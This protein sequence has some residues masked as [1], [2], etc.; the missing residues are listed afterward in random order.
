MTEITISGAPPSRRARV[1]RLVALIASSLA[2]VTC[3]LVTAPKPG[4]GSAFV[5]TYGGST[6]LVI[7]TP[8]PL[9]VTI[10][11]NGVDLAG[12]RLQVIS[13]NPENIDVTGDDFDHTLNPI[14]RGSTILTVKLLGSTFGDIPPDTTFTV[15]AVAKNLVVTTAA[16]TL[17]SLGDTL[18]FAAKVFGANNAELPGEG[19]AVRWFS[20]D[21]TVFSVDSFSGRVTALKNGA[22]VLQGVL[23][24]DVETTTANITVAQQVAHYT[25]SPAPVL[26]AALGDTARIT[27]TPRDSGGSVVTGVTL[28][29]VT[30]NTRRPG[31]VT[32][33]GAGLITGLL[34][35]TTY[36]VATASVAATTVADSVRVEVGQVAQQVIISQT[37]P[38]NKDA[39]NDTAKVTAIALDAR[40]V[41]I[42]GRGVIFQ[43]LTPSIARLTT[44]TTSDAVF[45]LD[46]TGTATIKAQL[47]GAQATIRIIVSN[48]ARAVG[49]SPDTLT[50]TTV[51]D[52]IP[53]AAVV[54]NSRG[55]TVP[56][57]ATPLAWVSLDPTVATVD[58][59]GRVRA[60]AVG[61]GHVAA[62]ITTGRPDTSV[63]RVFNLP[64][65][66]DLVPTAV[67]LASIG[68]AVTLATNI[69][70]ARGKQLGAGSVQW[71]STAPSVATVGTGFVS[72]LGTGTAYILAVDSLNTARRDSTLITVTNAPASVTLDRHLDTLFALTTKRQFTATVKN[73]R[74]VAT[75]QQ[76]VSWH[77]S[78]TGVATV[79]VSG[80]VTAQGIGTAFITADT[81]FGGNLV[82]DTARV[83][84]RNDVDHITVA[85]FPLASI[86]SLL[87]TVRLR[88]T[89]VNIVGGNVSG[90]AFQWVSSAPT[91]ASVNSTTGLVT[92]LQE[93]SA[94]ITVSLPSSPLVQAVT[95]RVEVSNLP[96]FID[97]GPTV[98]TLR[99]VN[100]VVIPAVTLLNKL[101]APLP[102]SAA[103]WLTDN[104]AVATVRND[105]ITA[106]GRGTAII[107]ARN[108]VS[109]QIQDA[110]TIVVTNAPFTVQV[111][112]SL[113]SLP[114]L[115]RTRQLGT[116]IRNQ[117]GDPLV[118][119]PVIWTSRA[120]GIVDVTAT[121]L[122]T[123]AGIGQ[124]YIVATDTAFGVTKADSALIK[125]SN[126]AATVSITP[127][128]AAITSVNATQLLTAKA[129]NESG[130]AITGPTVGWSSSSPTI[131]AFLPTGSGATSAGPVSF[132]RDTMRIRGLAAGT[133]TITA[134]VDGVPTSITVSVANDPTVV[135]ITSHDT[136]LASIGNSYTP[137]G[138]FQNSLGVAL[139][140]TAVLWSTSD[141]TVATVSSAGLVSAV[142]AGGPATIT[143]TSPANASL[144]ASIH[145]TVSNAP[146]T[147][148]VAPAATT[149]A[150]IGSSVAL[151]ATVRNAAGSVISSP[152]P[153]VT[154]T[155]GTPGVVGVNL[156]TGVATAAASGG[157]V[158]ITATAGAAVNTAQVTVTQV[159][160]GARSTIT[161]SAGSLTA[162]G[163]TAT[164]TVQLKDA[165]GVNLTASGGTVT[166]TLTGTGTL[167]AVVNQL[168]GTYTATLTAPTTLGTGTISASIGSSGITTGDPLVNY[169]A[170]AGNRYIVT[171][172]AATPI[173]GGAV[174]ITAQLTDANNNPVIA[175][176]KTV[177][178][179]NTG[180]GTF[181]SAT[182]LTN[183][184]GI[185]TVTYTTG[186]TAG[187]THNVT[188]TDNTALTGTSGNI[189]T[190]S[191]A[192]TKYV[193]TSSA[194]SAQAATDV[195]IT[196]Q[197]SDANNNP[198]SLAGRTV[199]W[200]KTG[201]G[202]SFASATSPT[203][204]NG[205][206][207]VVFTV[208]T[209]AGTVHTVTGTDNTAATGTSGN[210][211]VTSGAL[212][213]FL[214]E[215]V[216]GGPIGTHAAGTPFNIQVTARDA[217]NNTVAGFTGTVALSSTGALT[218]A[219]MTSGAFVAGILTTQAVTFTNTGSF[220]IT[221][222]KIGSGETGTSTPFTVNA[223][224]LDNFL[225]EAAGGGPIG[226][227]TASTP[228]NIR[229]TARDV[230]NN[231]T[232]TG[233][234]GTV[235]LTS[236]GLL[237][238][239]PL[240]SGAF[241]AGV[242]ASQ[243]VTI[244]NTG[245]FTITATGSGRNGTSAAF[246]VVGGTP[247]K[248]IVTSSSS[249]PGAGAGVTIT[250]QLSDVNNNPASLAGQTVTWSKTG[251]GGSF[252]S[253]TSVTNGSGV[254]TVVFTVHTVAGTV[255]TVT[256]S[257][258]S[259]FTG[260]SPNI[261]VSAGVATHYV[262]TSSSANPVAGA[263][264]TITAQ[265]ADG[266]NNPV[267]TAGRTVTW[268]KTGTGGTFAS[269]TS[270][271]NGSGVA[272][273]VF[274]TGT[275][276]GT[277]YTATGTDNTALTG[278]SGTFTTVAGT[279]T[280]YLVT[281]SSAT[282]A[283]GS[284][285][286]ITAQLSDA[287]NNPV[288]TAGKTVTWSKSGTGGSFASAT[289]LTDGNG[290]ATVVFTV[291]TLAGTVH[292]VTGTD[293]T[294]LAGTSAN[295]TVQAGTATQLA[296][297]TQPANT[298]AGATMATVRVAVQDVFGN[299]VTTNN[300][301][302]VTLNIG[303][304]PSAGTL[305]G[306]GALTVASGVATF[307]NLSINAAGNLYTLVATSNPALTTA[308][309]TDFNITP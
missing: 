155:S 95:T 208:H 53:L 16:A 7:G 77:T 120:P 123:A 212:D 305:S 31:S 163:S 86:G 288:A 40:G 272:T 188:A 74:N 222:T 126:L 191:G 224:T 36:V 214:L 110:I 153:A 85:Q 245:S 12:V 293:N 277:A 171:S 254:A 295:I 48:V 52:T 230:N 20:T 265:L 306:G 56:L 275:V 168:D 140:N 50:F 39:L 177:T 238:G 68:D 100:D 94:D 72:A 121:G 41:G 54:R 233:F 284:D 242:L 303:N 250:A 297:T 19:T 47:D 170:G 270:L 128:S 22:A 308:T 142:G 133:A 90:L 202:G 210:I 235:V 27:A 309:S 114:S 58:S 137:T 119:E 296:F 8:V 307:N 216:G 192:P 165:L 1:A 206:A 215:A 258:N 99:S 282:P 6:K 261:T 169:V 57:A 196:A 80:N 251:T 109:T 101:N 34:N 71:S 43:S 135:Q 256:A 302:T 37:D 127:G 240:T 283:A 189:Q 174:T 78:N 9:E 291:H 223:G 226:T 149:L 252:A 64:V 55:D 271:T 259:A 197:L 207:T 162:N 138:N 117:R 157:P 24:V 144:N 160:S 194:A 229:I 161:S 257:D 122:V 279:A 190:I 88:A 63:I 213:N 17:R 185:A 91:F 304:N 180:V 83:V 294:A 285:V 274:T 276:A 105:T 262:V 44:T 38:I 10:R 49:L 195:T 51:D 299:T 205:T 152:N 81:A 280:K 225:V 108:R 221:A 227:E 21:P 287:N 273:V 107:R 278:T 5:F 65:A 115:G 118:G 150:S 255:H 111:S 62:S 136:T 25:F 179:S 28:P 301:T 103:E 132:V 248:Y 249:T 60:V 82:F 46:R 42:T 59:I 23:H 159:A 300:T 232:T 73:A 200:S 183:A 35:D 266:S 13:S 124:T 281:S 4:A 145:V 97:I 217:G 184:S 75:A 289:S 244:T 219:P 175:P 116:S 241:T 30:F 102:D 11:Q 247:T 15:T 292:T 154:W 106:R 112:P 199:T 209:V 32:V 131:V 231:T 211:T 166:M 234:G 69:R 79:D 148:T 186:T 253:A 89:A 84:V 143:A 246:P 218:G 167:G 104:A 172:S 129:R 220:T 158:T 70:N 268:S 187:V 33:N 139:P 45:A 182:S 134:T 151:V 260:T 237:T 29:S 113:D 198:V 236:T 3:D 147:L 176:V 130:G 173:A 263:G 18:T 201:T 264:V 228:F 98:D 125:V 156:N 290:V 26:I 164:I 243:A 286:T 269:A 92:G 2:A 181:G 267:G 96:T 298:A 146:A 66:V 141:Q 178:W 93:G 67:T 76:S 203:L 87:D 239:T 204:P 193:V 14:K 61:T